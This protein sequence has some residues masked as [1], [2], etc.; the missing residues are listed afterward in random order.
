VVPTPLSID[1]QI[2]VSISYE[3][4]KIRRLGNDVCVYIDILII[5]DSNKEQISKLI[6]NFRNQYQLSSFIM[7]NIFDLKE[8]WLNRDNLNYP[9]SKYDEHF[10]AQLI[11]NKNTG[12]EK[13]YFNESK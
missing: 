6:N 2:K 5:G 7:I 9:Q 4:L 11:V 8:A 10:I 1:T 13:L 12:Y 3:I